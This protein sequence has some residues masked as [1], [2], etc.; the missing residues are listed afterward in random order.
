MK[1]GTLS[2]AYLHIINPLFYIISIFTGGGIV[3][4]LLVLLSKLKMVSYLK[5]FAFIGRH[6]VPILAL[7]L[8]CFKVVSFLQ[9]KIYGAER[10]V[11][12]LYPVWK[13]SIL[14]ASAYTFVGIIIPLI[15]V[16]FVI[17]C[18]FLFTV[19]WFCEFQD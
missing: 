6:T 3:Y 12:A 5:I 2:I 11:L 4:G 13:N 19:C 16:A 18:L 14:W 10:I 17:Y 15:F 7:H 8:L 9:W 1:F